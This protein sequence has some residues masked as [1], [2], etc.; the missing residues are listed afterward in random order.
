M[1][2]PPIVP[3]ASDPAHSRTVQ[4]LADLG[5]PVNVAFEVGTTE[6]VKHYVELELVIA[7]VSGICLAPEDLGRIEA[8]EIPRA[9]GGVTDYGVVLRRDKFQS[10]SLERFLASLGMRSIASH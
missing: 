3:E 2:Y 4:A 10:P 9:Y 5:L 1:Q 7:V 6:T 8:I